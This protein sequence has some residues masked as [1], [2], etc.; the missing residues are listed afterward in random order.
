MAAEW[1]A[2]V[3][4][5][6]ISFTEIWA[7]DLHRAA[8]TARIINNVLKADGIK[9]GGIKTEIHTDE[10]IKERYL[11]HWEGLTRV[12][13]ETQWPGAIERRDFPDDSERAESVVRRTLDFLQ[14]KLST[15]E[16]PEIDVS[17]LVVSHGGLITCLEEHFGIEWE[18]LSNLKGRWFFSES[19]HSIDGIQI[20]K[21]VDYLEHDI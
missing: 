4:K 14:E 7:S 2:A 17:Y 3:N 15:P 10:R 18:R 12:E 16:T 5:A 19:P 11:S 9:T 20:G 8:E 13:I 21:R 1:A 6:G